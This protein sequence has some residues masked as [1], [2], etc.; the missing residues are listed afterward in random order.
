MVANT[1]HLFFHQDFDGITSAAVFL[2]Y[3]KRLDL[4]SHSRVELVPVDY[5]LKKEWPDRTLPKP[6]AIVDFLYHPD[7][8]WWFDHHPTTFARTDWEL[9][10]REDSQ[11]IWNTSYK[12]CPRL[13]VDSIRDERVRH[14][15]SSR[16]EE[17]MHW[18]DVIDS[19]DYESA[20]QVVDS[21]DPA[22]QVNLSLAIDRS[23]DYLR[24]LIKHFEE[25]SLG[26]VVK[27]AEVRS[28]VRKA[29]E[30]QEAA[31]SFVAHVGEV[32]NGV[33]FC[34]LTSTK[35][36]FHRYAAYY[37]WPQIKFLVAVYK[38]DKG[39]K[40][41]VGANPWQ[42]F[43]GPDL[44]LLCERY[45]GGGHPEI[46]GILVSK[47]GRALEIAREITLILRGEKQNA[48]QLSFRHQVIR[49]SH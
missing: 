30:W 48:Q 33:A 49:Q 15:L 46:G 17:Y 4:L 18:S 14:A 27:L 23:P 29:M 9:S 11:H 43:R 44:S 1:F 19:A 5:E 37:L 41:T 13:I 12:S 20:Q 10:F 22:L 42:A 28:R 8:D 6:G 47:K 25:E 35:G 2:S 3:A 31:I 16:F 32:R 40:L 24:L 38:N 39:F 34:D 21:K 26:G 7:A 36:L 45:G